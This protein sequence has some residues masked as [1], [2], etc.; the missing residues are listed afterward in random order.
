[1]IKVN[2]HTLRSIVN[3]LNAKDQDSIAGFLLRSKI[4]L[5]PGNS[6]GYM[7]EFRSDQE[8]TLFILKYAEYL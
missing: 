7:L 6:Q 2:V 4:K 1:M 3:S 5:I 8:E